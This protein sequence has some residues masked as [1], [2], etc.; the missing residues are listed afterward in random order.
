MHCEFDYCVYNDQDACTLDEISIDMAG[1]CECCEV[2]NIPEE[3]IDT[4]KKKRL[5]EMQLQDMAE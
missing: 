3:I 1:M 2:F 4:Y 5:K